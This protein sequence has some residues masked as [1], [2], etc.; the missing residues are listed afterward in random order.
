MAEKY[1]DI[2]GFKVKYDGD[3]QMLQNAVHHLTSKLDTAE[4]KIFFDGAKRNLDSHTAHLEI[5]NPTKNR[6]DD[7]TLVHESDGS[8]HLKKREHPFWG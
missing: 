6:E 4:A 2:H 1:V 7:L 5:H 8:Y 3:S